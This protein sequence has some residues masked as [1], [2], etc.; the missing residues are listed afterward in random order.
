MYAKW[1]TRADTPTTTNNWKKVNI[2]INFNF[3]NHTK[4]RCFFFFLCCVVLF[5]L[6]EKIFV[7]F[8]LIHRSRIQHNLRCICIYVLCV[9]FLCD[10]NY[11][12]PTY[13]LWQCKSMNVLCVCVWMRIFLPQHR[14]CSVCVRLLFYEWTIKYY[15]F[16]IFLWIC[17]H[18][19]RVKMFVMC[20]L[21]KI[22]L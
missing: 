5:I 18:T 2:P 19:K 7:L 16:H 15:N 20:Y 8:F 10:I 11:V 22:Y 6:C 1:T 3:R 13:I 12:F 14:N 17:V 21:D 9:M 4:Q